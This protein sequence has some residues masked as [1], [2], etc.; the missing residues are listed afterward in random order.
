MPRRTSA[1]NTTSAS[2]LRARAGRAHED[3]VA[4]TASATMTRMAKYVA[5]VLKKNPDLTEEQAAR[6]ATLLLRADMADLA[7]KSAEA[8]QVKPSPLAD[9][10][11]GAC[12]A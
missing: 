2:G 6:A 11:E 4:M 8:R 1:Y 5:A 12:V 3:P 7:R 10:A 9:G